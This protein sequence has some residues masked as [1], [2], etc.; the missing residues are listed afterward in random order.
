[1]AIYP[2]NASHTELF[3]DVKY[4]VEATDN[5]WH[6]LWEKYHYQPRSGLPIPWEEIS[7]GKIVTIGEVAKRPIAI[8][9]SWAI[10]NGHKVMFY[11]GSSQ[12][13]DYKMMEKWL[14]HHSLNTIQHEGRWAKTNVSNFGHCLQA[15]GATKYLRSGK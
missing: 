5:E 10:I 2:F 9:I 8:Q 14:E 11:E 12:L 4:I 7:M 6:M 15:I 3:K 1:M 13:V